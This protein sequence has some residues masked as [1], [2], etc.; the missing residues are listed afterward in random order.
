MSLSLPACLLTLFL[1]VQFI[2]VRPGKNVKPDIHHPTGPGNHQS[3]E[4]KQG[5]QDKEIRS[6]SAIDARDARDSVI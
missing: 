6:S 5:C 2:F 1:S 4:T 3:K